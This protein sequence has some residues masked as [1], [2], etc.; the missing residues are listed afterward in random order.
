MI[1]I[2]SKPG[3]LGNLLLVYAS[4]LAWGFEYDQKVV[5]PAFARYY[6][7]FTGTKARTGSLY[8]GLYNLSYYFARIIDRFRLSNKLF[9]TRHLDWTEKV[10]LDAGSSALPSSLVCF[11]QGWQF[12]AK[13]LVE[14]HR[15]KIHAFFAPAPEFQQKLIDIWE[16]SI[17]QGHKVVGVHVRRGDYRTFEGGAYYFEPEIYE[18]LMRQI[19]SLFGTEQIVFLVC[20][21]D[22]QITNAFQDPNLKV[23]AG[24]GH[25]LLDLYALAKCHYLVGPP[26]TY[27]IWASFYGQVPLYMIHDPKRSISQNDFIVQPTF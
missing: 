6:R 20:S 15:E 13:D 26:S 24:P 4:L 16:H 22:Q 19:L 17:P 9:G 27:S 5:N 10:N 8:G 12:R 25:E 21:D 11:I 1:V 2:A 18:N 3:R 14:K 23:I 7:Y